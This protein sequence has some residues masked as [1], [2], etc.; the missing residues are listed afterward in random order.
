MEICFLKLETPPDKVILTITRAM[1]GMSHS[2]DCPHAEIRHWASVN[3]QRFIQS[4]Y[5]VDERNIILE[6]IEQGSH[7]T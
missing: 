1:Q 2:R 6:L 4:K 3:D 5:S 7:T